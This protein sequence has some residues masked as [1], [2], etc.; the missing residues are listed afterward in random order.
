MDTRANSTEL[1]KILGEQIPVL[2]KGFIRAVD[3]MGNDSS[4][5]QA[6]RVSYGAGTKKISE[7]AALIR[8]LMR[9]R[10]TTP[11]EMCEIKL[12]LKMPVFV[13]RQWVRHRTASINESSARYSVLNDEFYFPRPDRLMAQ[14][15]ENK[16]GSGEAM[17]ATE[18]AVANRL[19]R[20]DAARCHANYLE[21]IRVDEAAGKKGMARE[22]A[23]I[24]VPTNVY[25]EFYWKVNLHNLMH[26]LKLRSD[27]HAQYEIRCYAQTIEEQILKIWCPISFQAYV[28]YV[29]DSFTFSKQALEALRAAVDMGKFKKPDGVTDREW[30][31]VYKIILDDK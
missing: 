12:H 11:F 16:Q 7:D 1:N 25:T 23:R 15:T 29:R 9:M 22:L 6:A 5:V 8:Y 20:E 30:S 21:M 19:L 28:D 18:C 10:H 13:A 27:S 3:Y 17:S 24:N 14:S 26:F 4:V 31:S 2:D